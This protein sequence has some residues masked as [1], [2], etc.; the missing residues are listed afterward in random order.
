MGG[1]WLPISVPYEAL[2]PLF[3]ER[4]VIGIL[5]VFPFI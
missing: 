5:V 4:I 3:F 1:Y 2:F